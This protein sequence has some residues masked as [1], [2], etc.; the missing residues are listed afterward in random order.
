[1]SPEQAL[2]TKHA[3]ARA[4]V[5]S[6]GSTLFFLLTGRPMYLGDSY[7]K[8]ILAHR[9]EPI[10]SLA[11][12]QRRARGACASLSGW[13]PKIPTT[14]IGPW[15]QVYTALAACRPEGATQADTRN[16]SATPSSGEV[17]ARQDAA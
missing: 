4:D 5:Y 10:P 11:R 1:M 3:D 13:S 8:R 15:T 6:L 7:M 16:R 2:D 12:A 9:E 14:V 17:P